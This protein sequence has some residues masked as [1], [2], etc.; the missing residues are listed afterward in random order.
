MP[1]ALS[2]ELNVYE[3]AE[4]RF[5]T[6]AQKLS[7]EEGV[8]R[9][10]KYPS[11]EITVYVPAALDNGHLEV[12]SVIECCIPPCADRARAGFAS[13]RMFLST[14]SAHWLRG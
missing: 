5:E 1:V 13:L 6:A 2:D 8:Y 14:R 7:L 3:S 9:Y 12:L 4:A 10:L 11:R